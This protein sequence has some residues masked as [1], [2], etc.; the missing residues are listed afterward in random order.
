MTPLIPLSPEK[1][2]P[3]ATLHVCM[4]EHMKT[5]DP[6][7]LRE[8]VRARYGEIAEHGDNCCGG[9]S[10]GCCSDAESGYCEKLGYSHTDLL[11]APDG[12][13]LG[14]GCGNPTATASIRL[15]ETV[16]D[17]GSGAGFDCFL[18]ARQLNGTGRVIGVDMTSAMVT[19]ARANAHK[20][21][22]QNVEFRL[23]EIES[24]PVADSSVDLII[25][26]CV[27]NLSPDK[28]RVFREAFRVLKPGGRLAIADV[29]ATK[30]MP[31]AAQTGFD[32]IC[33]CIGGAAL[34][35][36]LKAMLKDAGFSTVKVVL[37]EETRQ[38]INQWTADEKAGDYVVS[39]LITAAKS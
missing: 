16:L 12:S 24:L 33:A 19:K 13:N 17:L 35:D 18:A 11:A 38:L 6:D 4:D 36:D 27:I 30:R 5:I 14:L 20:A 15:G 23:G 26:N 28:P 22:Y 34:V 32:T 29:V 8:Q 31:M 1:L 2:R 9:A 21:G 3:L 37:H 25:S 7:A 39:S 10:P